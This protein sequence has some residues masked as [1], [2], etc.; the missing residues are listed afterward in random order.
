[1]KRRLYIL[2]GH[3]NDPT[4]DEGAVSDN[5]NIHYIEGKLTVELRDLIVKEL[6]LMDAIVYTD[7]N[8]LSLNKVI[9]WLKKIL[10]ISDVVLDLHFNS[11]S[12]TK[13]N[14]TEVIIP[15]TPSN[16]EKTLALELVSAVSGNLNIKNRGVK[17][18]KESAHGKLAIMQLNCETVL[19]EVCFLSNPQ[20]MI[21]YTKFKKVLA[22]KLAN[23]LYKY[24]R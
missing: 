18:E 11:F 2:A 16:F 9:L 22:F 8:P 1:M 20:D 7:A 19:L 24:I 21:N 14:G 23:L 12:S 5:A 13:A 10:K 15:N 6:N 3:T 17:S 4:S